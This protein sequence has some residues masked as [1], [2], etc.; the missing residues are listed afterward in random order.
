MLSKTCR[1][2]RRA[3]RWPL[4]ALVASTLPVLSMAQGTN[5]IPG[6]GPQCRLQAPAT[7]DFNTVLQPSLTFNMTGLCTRYPVMW[8]WTAPPLDYTGH[9]MAGQNALFQPLFDNGTMRWT[10]DNRKVTTVN[11]IPI[12]ITATGTYT[13]AVR[14]KDADYIPPN[15]QPAGFWG[16][17]GAPGFQNIN[18]SGAWVNIT[19]TCHPQSETRVIGLGGGLVCSGGRV[20]S[21]SETRTFCAD[22]VTPTWGPWI[23]ATTCECPAGTVWDGAACVQVPVCT[24]TPSP[25]TVT[26]GNAVNWTVSCN[27][28]ATS[29]SWTPTDPPVSVPP[30]TAGLSCNQSYPEPDTVCYSV[31]GSN[32][33]GQGPASTPACATVACPPPQVWSPTQRACGV[34]PTITAP[35]FNVGTPAPATIPVTVTGTAPLTCTASNLPAQFNMS[36]A[37]QLTTTAVGTAIGAVPTGCVVSVSNPWGTDSKPCSSDTQ[38]PPSCTASWVNTPL[39]LAA[40]VYRRPSAPIGPPGVTFEDA[41][42][43]ARQLAGYNGTGQL[44]VA[45][46]NADSLTVSCSGSP[47]VTTGPIDSVTGIASASVAYSSALA[48]E[49]VNYSQPGVWIA[50]GLDPAY[51]GTNGTYSQYWVDS[52]GWHL[53]DVLGSDGN[54]YPA[55][56]WVTYSAPATAANNP[57]AQSTCTVTVRKSST[58]QTAQCS[59]AGNPIIAGGQAY[60]RMSVS[61]GEWLYRLTDG[62]QTPVKPDDTHTI[63]Q[64]AL[65]TSAPM[66][67]FAPN[68]I[69]AQVQVSAPNVQ[70]QSGPWVP[71]PGTFNPGASWTNPAVTCRK[72]IITATNTAPTWVSVSLPVTYMA[73][74]SLPPPWAASTGSFGLPVSYKYDGNVSSTSPAGM[75]G[76]PASTAWRDTV[77]S[78]NE[79]YELECSYVGNGY[80][81]ATGNPVSVACS[82]SWVYRPGAVCQPAA[83]FG[84]GPSGYLYSDGSRSYTGYVAGWSGKVGF[85][86]EKIT[87][88]GNDGVDANSSFFS[89]TYPKLNLFGFGASSKTHVIMSPRLPDVTGWDFGSTHGWLRNLLAN[90]T[91]ANLA[92]AGDTIATATL[93]VNTIQQ[94]PILMRGCNGAAGGS[95]YTPCNHRT[96]LNVTRTLF[97]GTASERQSSA[98]CNIWVGDPTGSSGTPCS[99][100]GSG[101]GSPFGPGNTGGGQTGGNG[102]G[103]NG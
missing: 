43:A 54:T 38:P 86:G 49:A 60:C 23:P 77:D 93:G 78:V 5:P 35:V 33:A 44:A 53:V 96:V 84:S 61:A 30:C 15:N 24:V 37:C 47:A 39:A 76:E 12:T 100:C 81:N 89:S 97:P 65:S 88:A 101:T 70:L 69:Y 27:T 74:S 55:P 16:P 26:P 83:T 56:G 92:L 62:S 91:D 29:V 14:A 51:G 13:F 11:T 3:S 102:Q 50:N 48:L 28:P 1:A 17:W 59:T 42:P 25:A 22:S 10:Y 18:D 9:N 79:Q 95:W 34:P 66:V 80:D 103:S 20:S 72:R 64:T 75:Y 82:S 19:A 99:T 98:Q 45:T 58:G 41:N 4:L 31:R 57:P 67:A 32:A 8:E 87:L 63:V 71:P 2:I 21:L 85:V 94:T 6:D 40:P 68:T 7:L 46:S 36:A 90:Y 73:V 52:L